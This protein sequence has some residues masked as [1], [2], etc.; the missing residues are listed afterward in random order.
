VKGEDVKTKKASI[1]SKLEVNEE[2]LAARPFLR[3]LL[4][5]WDE[6]TEKASERE[7]AEVLMKV[8]L[9]IRKLC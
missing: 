2:L 7:K 5:S 3:V 6:V 8:F 1:L 9:D 4:K